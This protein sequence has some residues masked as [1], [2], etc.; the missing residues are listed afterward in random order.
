V[1]RPEST[2]A[3]KAGAVASRAVVAG[4]LLATPLFALL[5]FGLGVPLRVAGLD[6]P[7]HR[8]MY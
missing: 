8:G 7:T 6:D 5:D 3:P 2:Q 1:S 4:Y